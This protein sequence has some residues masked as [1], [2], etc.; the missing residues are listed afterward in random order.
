MLNL[1]IRLVLGFYL[2]VA[3][4][5]CKS[6]GVPIVMVYHGCQLS[7]MWDVGWIERHISEWV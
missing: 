6:T 4:L 2:F 1:Q 5:G 3:E 7:G